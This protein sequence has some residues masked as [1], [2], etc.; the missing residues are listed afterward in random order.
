MSDRT[1]AELFG[2][3]FGLLASL[4]KEEKTDP[5]EIAHEF[6]EFLEKGSYDFAHY[7]MDCDEA[8]IELGLAK[9]GK[10]VD[11]GLLY[12]G[13]KGFETS[14]CPN[15]NGSSDCDECFGDGTAECPYCDGEEDCERCEDGIASCEICDGT[16]WCAEC[17]G[18][19]EV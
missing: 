10:E 11:D 9:E 18:E 7:Q 6:W 8:L 5:Q 3:I 19:G 15:C 12:K 17:G 14:V 1:S 4:K 2:R 13:E 16:G